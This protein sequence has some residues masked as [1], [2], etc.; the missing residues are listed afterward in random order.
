MS[1]RLC[2][3]LAILLVAALA[4][5]TAVSAQDTRA[6]AQPDVAE[7]SVWKTIS[8]GG[9]VVRYALFNALDSQGIHVGDAAQ[10]AL[11]RVA[12]TFNTSRTDVQLVQMSAAELGFGPDGATL[13]E[14]Y[15]RALK[16]GLQLCP[17]E[18]A[19]QLRLQYQDQPRGRFLHVAMLPIATYAGELVGLSLGNGGAG[20]V[21]TG[22]DGRLGEKMPP[23]TAFV[24]VRPQR[25]ARSAG[26]P[27]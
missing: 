3:T 13:A 5:V 7:A 24:F 25:I 9:P 6:A 10:E 14:I 19:P 12:F 1:A 27:K 2:K 8:L 15:R 4:P 17:A 26:A 11:H 16:L 22:F 21:L 23:E 18:V 20:L